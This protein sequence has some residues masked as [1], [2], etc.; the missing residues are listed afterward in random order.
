LLKSP[1]I[2]EAAEL[3]ESAIRYRLYA[4]VKLE[5]LIAIPCNLAHKV[6]SVEPLTERGESPFSACRNASRTRASLGSIR[7]NANKASTRSPVR[8]TA[9]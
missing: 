1:A 6:E 4:R 3:G 9:A 7:R 5:E 8:S 2:L